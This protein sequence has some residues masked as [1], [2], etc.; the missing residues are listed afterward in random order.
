MPFTIPPPS[1]PTMPF[2]SL[3]IPDYGSDRLGHPKTPTPRNGG[4]GAVFQPK[5]GIFVKLYSEQNLLFQFEL[6]DEFT[7]SYTNKI[8]TIGGGSGGSYQ[9]TVPPVYYWTGGEF[10]GIQLNMLLSSDVEG[11]V[12]KNGEKANSTVV[13]A[14][15]MLYKMAMVQK[16][17]EGFQPPS[18]VNLEIGQWYKRKGIIQ[19][20]DTTFRP[21]YDVATGEPRVAAIKMT[22]VPVFG[23]LTWSL[24]NTAGIPPTPDKTDVDLEQLPTSATFAWDV[25]F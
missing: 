2:P 18:I 14:T 11:W 24:H 19:R 5:D 15:E 8:Q 10:A 9:R 16:N 12:S 4:A 6:Q 3:P 21:P 25:S 17:L 13:K 1:F 22:F 7:E 20:L 23:N